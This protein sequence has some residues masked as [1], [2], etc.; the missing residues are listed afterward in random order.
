MTTSCSQSYPSSWT[1]GC[2]LVLYSM[3]LLISFIHSEISVSNSQPVSC[4]RTA[5]LWQQQFALPMGDSAWCFTLRVLH[6]PKLT[7]QSLLVVVVFFFLLHLGIGNKLWVPCVVLQDERFT[8]KLDLVLSLLHPDLWAL[9]RLCCFSALLP[10]V[11]Y[12]PGS[13]PLCAWV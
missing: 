9:G 11:C 13:S 12:P 4:L 3:H 10:A 5:C 6:W 8:P 2:H 1:D 7:K